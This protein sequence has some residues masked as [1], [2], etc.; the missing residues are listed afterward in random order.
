MD[1]FVIDGVEIPEKL[2]REEMPNHPAPTSAEAHKQAAHAL[3]V[4]ALLLNRAS[5]LGL[6]P[7]P[8]SDDSGR[9]ETTE[10]ALIR[11]LFAR[12]LTPAAPT[13][14]ECRR[15]FDAR[16]QHFFTPELYEASHILI[17]ESARDVAFDL[18]KQLLGEPT[19]FEGLA[20]AL[21]HCPSAE[22]GGSLGQ[23]QIGDLVA[24][25]E[26]TLLSMPVGAIYP[27]PVASRFGWHILRLDRRVARQRLPYEAVRERIRMHLESRA[28]IAA[29]ARYVETLVESARSQGIALRMGDAGQVER[30]S[31]FLGAM[32][33]DDTLA[34]RIA[35]WLAAVDPELAD[36]VAAAADLKGASV[37]DFIRHEVR[38]FLDNADDESFT[39]LVSAAQGADDPLLASV[40]CVLK[41]R[42]TPARKTFSLIRKA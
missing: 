15:F 27:E 13:E 10:E 18:V 11:Q 31:L 29:S 17:Q 33:D 19:A 22:V 3:A 5:A 41:K 25:V 37:A 14:G 26:E 38:D 32:I 20:R 24:E 23:L 16:P 42:L 21:S 6:E 2:I 28:W 12:E 30:P 9:I 36:K 4:K 40:T 35:P 34:G 7:A 39:Q 8:E 1:V